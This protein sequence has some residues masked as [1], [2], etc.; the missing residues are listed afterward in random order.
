MVGII[1][2]VNV[3]LILYSY[4]LYPLSLGILATLFPK[5]QP[6]KDTFEPMV[7]L[8][9]AAYNEKDVIAPKLENSLLLDY[10]QERLQIL[11]AADGSDDGTDEIVKTF[12]SR[13][14]ELSFQP[15]RAGKVVAINNAL[16]LVR[17]EII[18]M[19]DANNMYSKNVVRDLVFPFQD[20]TVGIT[21]GAK[22]IIKGDGALGDSEGLYWKYESWI[23]QK[24]TRLGCATGAAG[25]ANAIRRSL[26]EAPPADI[27]NDDFYLMMSIIKR[28]YRM[29]YVPEAASFERISISAKDE[30]ERRT[31]IVAGRYQAIA[32]SLELLPFRRP[33]VLWQIISHKFLR[34][35]VPFFMLMVFGAALIAAIFPVD[36]T[37]FDLTPPYGALALIAQILFYFFAW[38]GS[39][40]GN[41]SQI[42][43]LL[44]LSTFFVNSNYAAVL[45]LIRYLSGRQQVQWKRIRRREVNNG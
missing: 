26:F 7:T 17:G 35:L 15:E 25:E 12:A 43:R 32:R 38:L 27:I 42:G 11:V 16:A 29:I 30:I 10:P 41:H 4:F 40:I 36:G 44:Y 21:N 1:F 13:G 2:W 9:I 33:L 24:E 31:R 19:S 34:P 18:V 6:P 23:K 3:L 22:K 45:G 20:P 14:V 28:G 8:L 37:L 39:R 5:V